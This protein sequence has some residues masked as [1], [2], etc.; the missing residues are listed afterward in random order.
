M[1]WS[2]QWEPTT[3]KQH[4]AEVYVSRW[5]MEHSEDDP[6]VYSSGSDDVFVN[7]DIGTIEAS[8]VPDHDLLCGGFPC[9]A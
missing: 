5:D 6:D 2:N 7:K 8:D 9:Q 4:A 1:V 3:K